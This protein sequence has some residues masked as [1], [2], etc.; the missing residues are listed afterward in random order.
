MK[1]N[2]D[3]INKLKVLYTAAFFATGQ[4]NETKMWSDI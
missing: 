3:K 4:A 1:I 2:W